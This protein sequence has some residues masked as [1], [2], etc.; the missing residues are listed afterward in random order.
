VRVNDPLTGHFSS[1]IPIAPSE[2]E[3]IE[4]LKGASSAIYGSDAVGGVV[5]IIT[6][7]FSASK[8][9][10]E[11]GAQFTTGAYGLVNVNAGGFYS[12]ATTSIATGF[13]SNNAKGQQ[14]RGIRGHF[15]LNTISFSISHRL[16]ENWKVGFRSALDSRKFAAQNFYTGL[17]ID[18]ATE[19]VQSSWN[20]LR[21]N[22][23]KEKNSLSVRIGHKT[24]EDEY[25]LNPSFAA[26]QNR[27]K[28]VQGLFVFDHKFTDNSTLVS[29]VQFQNRSIRSNDR[30]NHEVDQAAVFSML[31]HNFGNLFISP[32]LRLEWDE[33]AGSELV[34]QV[35]ASYRLNNLHLRGSAGRTIRQADFTERYNNYNRPLVTGGRI[36]N[37]DLEAESS[38]SYEGGLDYLIGDQLKISSSYFYRRYK[39]LID[40]AATAYNEMPRRVNLITTGKY[41]LSK[42]IA[43][44]KTSGFETDVQLVKPLRKER[45]LYAT[46]GLVIVN[47]ETSEGIP[48]LYLT[49]Y[50]RFLTNFVVQYSAPRYSI[51]ANGL[52]KNRKPQMGSAY[53]T[54]LSRDYFVMNLKA[55]VYLLKKKLSLFAQA[56]NLLNETYTDVIGT[57]MPGRWWMGGLKLSLAK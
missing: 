20:Q 40:W 55:E 31:Q 47:S 9:R 49:S 11:I 42:N 19:S 51:S 50:A 24:S 32:A 53:Y 18:T 15:N 46:W 44:V 38:W 54:K 39:G 2:I 37:P 41:E 12:D 43:A 10:K 27:A 17:V 52:Y 4:I 13:L 57:I 29:G 3:R 30:G 14:Q 16:N 36:G 21:V 7:T 1:Y 25:K 56:D 23:Q 45:Q 35:N 34:P 48:S 8:E 5:H 26:N 6:K 28:L 22:Y 33:R